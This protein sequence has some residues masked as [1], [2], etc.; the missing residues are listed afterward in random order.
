MQHWLPLLQRQRHNRQSLAI[1]TLCTRIPLCCRD[2]CL[3]RL[4]HSAVGQCTV[5]QVWQR[6]P[7]LKKMT[8]GRHANGE[9]AGRAAQMLHYCQQITI[10]A[11][12]LGSMRRCETPETRDGIRAQVALTG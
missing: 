5:S 2:Q 6:Q 7:W 4:G 3:Y 11:G 10:K 1:E 9:V 12:C 8:Q